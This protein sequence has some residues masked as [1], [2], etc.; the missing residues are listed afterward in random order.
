MKSV[1]VKFPESLSFVNTIFNTGQK[2]VNGFTDFFFKVFFIVKGLIPAFH[3]QR[4]DAVATGSVNKA[5]FQNTKLS[6]VT[7]E[8]GFN[9]S[10]NL[11]SSTNYS[12][13]T[14]LGML[15]AL[16]D[17]TGEDTATLTLGS[18]NLSKLTDA[19]KRIAT[20][21]NWILA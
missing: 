17:R 12:V 3:R 16:A 14:L 11:Q 1:F 10:L 18:T 4:M 21:K 2:T 5:F 8:Q 6:S 9:C 7:L 13:E 20:E 19:Q 15:N